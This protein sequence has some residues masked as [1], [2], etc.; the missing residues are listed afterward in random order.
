MIS[1][2]YPYEEIARI[3]EGKIITWNNDKIIRSFSNRMNRVAEGSLYF[4]YEDWEDEDAL[5]AEMTKRNAAGIVINRNQKLDVEKW[6]QAG[7]G[8]LGVFMLDPAYYNLARF[9]RSKIDIPIV[10]VIGSSGKT[11]TKEMIGAILQ[12][13]MPALV[14]YAN[15]NSTSGIIAQLTGIQDF[16]K[17]AVIEAGMKRKGEMGLSSS[18][19][20]PTSGVVT[21][22]NR[23][24]F[25]RM[26]SI[27]EIISAKAEMLEYLS[28]D[29]CLIINGSDENCSRFPVERY[30]GKVLTFGFS[31]K[32]D[33]WASDI[34]YKNFTTTFKAHYDKGTMDC[35]LNAV[36]KYNVSNALAAIMVG[37]KI[38][39]TPDNI[40]Q[41]LLRFK[42]FSS[43][44]E[45][46]KGIKGTTII[47]DNYNAN[48]D[49]TGMLLNEIPAFAGKQPVILVMGDMENPAE[50]ISDYARKV[51]FEIGEQ[52]GRLKVDGLFAIGKWAEEY[53]N[54]AAGQGMDRAKLHYF[55][56]IEDA[57]EAL[58]KN[59][60][61]GSIILFKASKAY[62]DLGKL[63]S[64]LRQLGEGQYGK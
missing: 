6:S 57:G 1:K 9:Y 12:Y 33:I 38:G 29:G 58:L 8:I 18:I 31:D 14:G 44:M 17:A 41:G 37:L 26:G 47:N 15:L 51:H 7:L 61:A 19:V 3:I 34:R 4:F 30:K 46:L 54:G 22:I 45:I 13:S 53:V 49:S 50:E 56:N 2:G 64:M 62:V 60:T 27:D 40:V 55:K 24:H 16:H 39:I 36:G 48:P 25:A 5:I 28:E 23:S 42:P 32:C 10:E 52:I 21:G 63:I 20:R 35:T 43:R 11:T 59:I